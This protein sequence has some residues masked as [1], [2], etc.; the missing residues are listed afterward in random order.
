VFTVM[1]SYEKGCGFDSSHYARIK[2][3]L[4]CCTGSF[5]NLL[6]NMARSVAKFQFQKQLS[7][8]FT[9][10]IMCKSSTVV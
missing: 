5:R 1:A 8:I 3:N 4:S 10:Q 7:S 9:V 6:L 2:N